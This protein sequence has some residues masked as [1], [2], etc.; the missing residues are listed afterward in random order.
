MRNGTD[1]SN[2]SRLRLSG[3]GSRKPG[4]QRIVDLGG[5]SLKDAFAPGSLVERYHVVLNLGLISDN[6]SMC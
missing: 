6:L 2:E 4:W 5:W 1:R 3:E